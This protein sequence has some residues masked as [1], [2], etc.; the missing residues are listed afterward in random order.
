MGD[1]L[2]EKDIVLVGTGH[3]ATV[4]G[5]LCRQAGHRVL[6]VY[7]RNL[8]AAGELAAELGAEALVSPAALDDRAD[9]CIVAISDAAL[10]SLG[11]WMPKRPYPVVHTAGSVSMEVLSGISEQIGVLYPLQSLRKDQPGI[12]E[13]PFMVQGNSKDTEHLLR[14]FA[15]SLSGLVHH[16]GEEERRRM[17]LAAVFTSNFFNH[18]ATLARQYCRDNDVDFQM[19]LPLL[20]E[21]VGRMEWEDP[22]NLQTGPAIRNDQPTIDRHVSMLQDRPHMQRIYQLM[23]DSIRHHYNTFGA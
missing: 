12:P 11:N 7:G 18:L 20:L 17:H 6:Q 1:A 10:P 2:A 4:L 13:I 19:L 8:E 9:M 22:A 3:V 5:R 16:A 23:T 21:T 14:S 15:R